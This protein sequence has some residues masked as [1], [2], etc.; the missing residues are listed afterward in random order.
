M[1]SST[2]SS[3]RRAALALALAL[4][5]AGCAGRQGPG[6]T[7]PLAR[8]QRVAVL[9]VENLG[10]TTAPLDEVQ[11]AVEGVVRRAGLEVVTGAPDEAFLAAHR[12]RWTG[13]ID[14]AAAA[15]AR[16]ELGVDGVVVTSIV[17]WAPGGVPKVSLAMRAVSVAGEPIIAWIDAASRSGD[18]APGWFGTG[19]TSS[20][21]EVLHRALGGLERS[22]HAAVRGKGPRAT[23]CDGGDAFRPKVAFRS[24]ELAARGPFTVAVLPFVDQTPHRSGGAVALEFVRRLVATP[25]VRVVEPG[26]VRGEVVR[27]R[28]GQD[29]GISLEQARLVADVLDVD[30]LLAGE[31]REDEDFLGTAQ[32]PKV[33]FTAH[34]LERSRRRLLWE[35]RSGNGGDDA[36][37]LFGTGR[38]RTASELACRMVTEVVS[39]MLGKGV[40][41][42]R[43]A[44]PRPPETGE[45][46]APVHAPGAPA[47]AQQRPEDGPAAQALRTESATIDRKHLF[48]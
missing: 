33:T 19:R 28:I 25:G 41:G 4:A 42:P 36:A 47:P 43:R 12:L 38:V 5:H 7:P 45:T 1:T 20:L 27:F 13:G 17:Q 8:G 21:D 18:D 32:P 24:P 11:R 34:L 26:V 37:W 3:S 6:A 23:A 31:V 40:A 16:D 30:L 44:A 48:L 29:E 22:L 46:P 9:P 39:E 2:S 15:A 10:G 14:R 35:S